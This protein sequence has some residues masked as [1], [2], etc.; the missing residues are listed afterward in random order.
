MKRYLLAA[1]A[2]MASITLTFAQGTETFTNMPAAASAYALRSWT[3]DNTLS[4][5][6]TDARTDQQINSSRAITIRDGAITCNGIPNGVGNLSF[7]H[8][9]EFGGAGG[10]LEVRINGI[11]VGTANP[12]VTAQTTTLTNINIAGAFNLEIKQVTPGL[13]ISVDNVSWIGYNGLACVTPTAQPS[14]LIFGTITNTSI[15][16]SFTAASPTA[17]EY[18]VVASTSSTLTDIPADG[19]DYSDGDILGNGFIV[20]M[21]NVLSFTA[22]S[23]NPGTT[24]YFSV[25]AVNNSCSGGPKYLTTNPLTGNATTTAPPVCV[26]PSAA[27]TLLVLTPSSTSI[28]GSFTASASADGYLVIISTSATLGATP[29]NGTSYTVGTS[30][31]GGTIVKFGAGTTFSATGLTISTPYYLYVFSVSNFNCTGG[32]LYFG[33]A[34][35]GNTTTTAGGSGEPPSYY[36]TATGLSCAALKTALKNI[37]T[38][39]NTLKSYG[40]LWSQY[41]V[42]DIKTREVGSGSA[43]VIWDVYSDNPTGTDPYNFTPG[44]AQCGNYS[45]EGDCYNRE[46][47]FP[48]NWFTSGT[49][50]G[51]GTDYIQVLPTDGK[52]NGQRSNWVYS[53][54]A[55]A[56]WTSLNG[57]KLGSS[58]VAGISGTVFEPINTYKGDL[59]R[60]FL[61]MVTRYEN[62]MPT[63]GSLSG[64]NGLQALEP[65]TFPS[66]DVD[67]LRLMIKWHNQDPVSQKEIDRNNA[68]YAY[69]GNRN[70]FVDRPEFV[71]QVWNNTC[72]GLSTLPVDIIFF[73]GKLNGDKVNLNWLAE[74]EI[75]FD[76]FEVQRSS[77]GV[78]YKTVGSVIANNRRN[79]AF[80]DDAN[81]IRGRRVYYRLK[82]VDKDGSFKYS[83][84]VTL[85]I[86]L[87]TKFTVSPNPA[88]QYVQLQLNSNVSGTVTIE[89]KDIT[90]KTV[91]QQQQQANGGTINLNTASVANG[92]YVIRLL[93]NGEQYVQKVLIAR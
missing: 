80:N 53:E 22:N 33:T 70:P 66:V 18:L 63:W 11:L 64:S 91:L 51:P 13:R 47:T 72:P 27:A 56:S 39:G 73:T 81:S 23:L 79:Y 16:G 58:S 43:N 59:A 24:Y 26:A 45:S 83:E 86:P 40:D 87:N 49:S 34:L 77:N 21:S 90:G 12:T 32:P 82:K 1:I 74:N 92:T 3:G 5:S 55:S 69:Q 93:Y 61:Y 14:N 68:A 89:L 30:F 85:H 35:T 29:T 36:S 9:Q 78:D 84:V 57:S 7:T 54:V 28:N 20:Q 4:W 75:N 15:A 6:A 25:F 46:H 37:I 17:D 48:Q 2:V 62:N 67:Y 10:V 52:V 41:Q 88:N 60:I 71:A 76:R 8:E 31:G 44:T 42:S 65:N 50:T 19:I 38:T